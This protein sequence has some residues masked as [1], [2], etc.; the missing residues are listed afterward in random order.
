MLWHPNL[1]PGLEV[2]PHST[3]QSGK[4]ASLA[5]PVLGLTSPGYGWPFWLP[6]HTAGSH[7][8]CHQPQCPEP[9]SQGFSPAHRPQSVRTARAAPPQEQSP[10]HVLPHADGNQPHICPDLS[11]RPLYSQKSQ[12]S[13][14]LNISPNFTSYNC[15]IFIGITVKIFKRKDL[16][17]EPCRNPLVTSRTT[18]RP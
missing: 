5:S 2:R 13:S 4:T 17:M 10:A 8:N 18:V 12:H 3:E 1:H 7:P 14:Q 9:F 6:G 15:Q 16:K 11:A